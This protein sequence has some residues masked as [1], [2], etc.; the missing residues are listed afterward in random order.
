MFS[1]NF[2]TIN[3]YDGK[4]YYGNTSEKSN[5]HIVYNKNSHQSFGP[6]FSHATYSSKNIS[7]VTCNYCGM[8]FT[9]RNKLFNH[10]GYN[11]VDIRNHEIKKKYCVSNSIINKN[12]SIG[13][14]SYGKGKIRTHALL[15]VK[16][17]VKKL[18]NKL[19]IEN[20]Y[21]GDIEDIKLVK[22]VK[23]VNSVNSIKSVKPINID[24]KIKNV[25]DILSQLNFQSIKVKTNSPRN[26]ELKEIKNES[27]D[28]NPDI[29]F[30]QEDITTI[31]TT[32][33][34]ISL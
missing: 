19:V 20:G 32:I 7:R 5:P 9:S 27:E 6:L 31:C 18:S 17:N 24:R 29:E 11:N 14:N 33:N 22:S 26:N 10:L 23:S 30:N 15:P 4:T 34:N 16:Y 8:V 25:A 12:R 13:K 28:T 3:I 21:D 2:K 1:K